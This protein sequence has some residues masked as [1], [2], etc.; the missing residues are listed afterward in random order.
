M[1][2]VLHHIRRAWAL[3]GFR[4]DVPLSRDEASRFLP[5]I[6]AL[7]VYLT[8]LTLAGSFSLHRTVTAG[9]NAQIR[10]FSVNL[11]HMA[12]GS[13][14][15]AR[16]VLTLTQNT[17][18]VT[19]ATIINTGRIKEM[20]EPWLGKSEA[21]NTLPLP[22]IIEAKFS[23]DAEIDFA[24][25]KSR[26]ALLVP[27]ADIDDHKQWLTQFSGFI[28]MVQWVLTVI[29]LFI[30]ATT[31]TTVVFACKTSL[32]IHRNTVNLLHRLGAVDGYI[33]SQFQQH[34]ALLALKGAF[35]GS[36]FAAGTMLAIHLM[37]RH[38]DS[39]LFPSFALLPSH[40]V[41]LLTLPLIMS[42]LALF[43]ARISV[44]ATLRKMP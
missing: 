20:V 11:P 7:M 21:L 8:A 31:A 9:H 36:G 16:K 12:A 24:L 3:E 19:E 35:V 18:G 25:L 37:A 23:P 39:P 14:E 17:Q 42:L 28:H 41:I 44:L 33:A 32:K 34:A 29:A 30:I 10:S 40:W 26:I 15:T 38:I 1:R 13:E 6:I 4:P 27:D 5:W 22:V 2:V 43:S